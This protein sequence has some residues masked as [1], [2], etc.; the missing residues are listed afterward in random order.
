MKRDKTP[1]QGNFQTAF[2][3]ISGGISGDLHA[4]IDESRESKQILKRLYFNLAWIPIKA[5]LSNITI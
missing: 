5:V 1:R 4:A 3:R 2:P